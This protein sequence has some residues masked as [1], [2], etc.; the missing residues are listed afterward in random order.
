M[1]EAEKRTSPEVLTGWR[2]R[3][4]SPF[5]AAGVAGCAALPLLLALTPRLAIE[6]A[7]I[8]FFLVY[9]AMMARRVPHLTVNRLKTSRER[10]DAPAYTIMI[11]T[12]LAVVAAIGA[13]FNALNRAHDPSLF[14]VALAFLSVIGGWLTIHTMFAMHYAHHYW[15][16]V[17]DAQGAL[18][19][20]GGLAFPETAEPTGTD[21]LYFSF[22]IGMTAQTSDVTITTTA[23][24][25]INLLHSLLSFFFNT[26]L[27]AAAVNAVVSLAG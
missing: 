17:P 12:L 5:Y 22:I 20:Q 8:L 14:E 1:S 11:V 18:H 27:V 10:D 13:L 2:H 19:L 21:F 7:A 4:H 23:L 3:R 6:I 26:V 16:R 9:L 25:R 24:R 15:R